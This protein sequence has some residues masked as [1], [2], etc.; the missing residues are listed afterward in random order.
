MGL[1]LFVAPV[2]S[3]LPSKAANK[4]RATSPARSGI[5]RNAR[6]DS[7]ERR[8]TIRRAATL[9]E[10]HRVAAERLSQSQSRSTTDRES[11]PVPWIESGFPPDYPSAMRTTL[12]DEERPFREVLSEMARIDDQHRERVGEH[13][14][15]LVGGSWGDEE[16]D[17][18]DEIN[19]TLGLLPDEP[20]QHYVPSQTDRGEDTPRPRQGTIDW[21]LMHIEPINSTSVRGSA[22]HRRRAELRRRDF[23]STVR[24]QGY[25]RGGSEYRD[26]ATGPR[27]TRR[28]TNTAPVTAGSAA[29]AAP[30]SRDRAQELRWSQEGVMRP[31]WRRDRHGNRIPGPGREINGLGD[32]DRS[33]SPEVWDTLLTTLTPDPQPPS[34]GSSFASTVASQSA[35][36]SSSTSLTGPET[37]EGVA[38]DLACDS[39]CENSDHEGPDYEHPEFAGIRRRRERRDES[40]RVRLRVPD[41]NVDG[42]VDGPAGTTSNG[43][44]ASANSV[45][46]ESRQGS[47]PEGPLLRRRSRS[48][49]DDLTDAT[50]EESLSLSQLRGQ[51]HG[52][53]GH[54]SVG[55]SDDEQGTERRSLNRESSAVSGNNTSQ[56]EEDWAGMLRIVRSLARREDIPDEWWAEAGLSRTLPEAGTD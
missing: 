6:P 25:T 12:S 50:G 17:S 4:N 49:G 20:H 31:N 46:S 3:D 41:Y 18:R 48:A 23:A 42:P 16:L 8:A 56:G 21:Q 45:G 38:A 40:R 34:A 29:R 26:N 36:V 2:E 5:R 39:G 22:E 47:Q 15:V 24:I 54:L 19:L 33:L 55:N 35:G 9:R 32:R 53:V 7:R 51:R 27:A 13:L 30:R 1:P 10:H 44:G 14:N 28:Y 52:W 11:R 37:I 43:R